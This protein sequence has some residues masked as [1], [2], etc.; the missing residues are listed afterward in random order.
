MILHPK[1]GEESKLFLTYFSLSLGKA[2]KVE[3]S[4]LGKDRSV[5]CNNSDSR[6]G[7]PTDLT[8]S[9]NKWMLTDTESTSFSIVFVWNHNPNNY[10]VTPLYWKISLC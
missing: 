4:Q 6:S 3:T 7:Q 8:Q 1:D 2:E 9:W 10:G 5:A